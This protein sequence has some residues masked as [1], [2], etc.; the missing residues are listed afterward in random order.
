MFIMSV[1]L[2]PVTEHVH[3]VIDPFM[4]LLWNHNGHIT[5]H[6]HDGYG[7]ADGAVPAP[8]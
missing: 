6:Y 5:G 7:P 4:D 8:I 1:L 3:T 2:R